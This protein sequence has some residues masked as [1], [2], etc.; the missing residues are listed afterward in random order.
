M[1]SPKLTDN[2]R[3][4]L[5]KFQCHRKEKLEKLMKKSSNLVYSTETGRVKQTDSS[6]ESRPKGDGIIRLHR[7]TKGRKGKG[8]T[9]ITGFDLNDSELK[10]MAKTLKQHCGTGGSVKDG[11]IEIQ[12]DQRENLFV[13]L[14][15]K[16][17]QVKKAGG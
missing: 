13:Y 12:G 9:L 2:A 7:E 4:L 17:Y 3:H 10:A 15:E 14:K 1:A 16:G 11:V 5:T 6:E 8:V